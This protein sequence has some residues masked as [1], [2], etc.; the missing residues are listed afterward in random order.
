[1]RLLMLF[2]LATLA[3]IGVIAVLPEY[4]GRGLGKK[5][6]GALLNR[7]KSIGASFVTV[8]GNLD[9][10]SKPLELYRK[11]GFTGDDIWYICQV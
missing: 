1:M 10:A 2:A 9:N 8:S 6:V 5:I 3:V 4:R 11:C 7:L